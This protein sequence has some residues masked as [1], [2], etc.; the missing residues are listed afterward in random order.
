LSRPAPSLRGRSGRRRTNR[1]GDRARGQLNGSHRLRA[2]Y[3][4]P[5]GA[6]SHLPARRPNPMRGRARKCCAARGATENRRVGARRPA[7]RRQ[8]LRSPRRPDELTSEASSEHPPSPAARLG[9]VGRRGFEASH[10]PRPPSSASRRVLEESRASAPRHPVFL[11]RACL[12]PYT[13]RRGAREDRSILS[14]TSLNLKGLLVND[15]ATGG[16]RSTRC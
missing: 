11:P 10:Y 7:S 2:R 9:W 13:S 4:P 6:S 14:A 16:S 8:P 5:A 15:S 12:R 1:S 3:G